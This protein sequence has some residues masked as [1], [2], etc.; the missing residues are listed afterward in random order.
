MFHP[1]PTCHDRR[2]TE[3]GRLA[4]HLK[5]QHHRRR[6]RAARV[7]DLPGHAAFCASTA[8]SS[9][10]GRLRRSSVYGRRGQNTSMTSAW[11]MEGQSWQKLH[12]PNIDASHATLATSLLPAAPPTSDEPRRALG[13]AASQTLRDCGRL[14]RDASG[15]SGTAGPSSAAEGGNLEIVCRGQPLSATRG[16]TRA[17]FR[18]GSSNYNPRKLF[19]T[20]MGTELPEALEGSLKRLCVRV[21]TRYPALPH[22]LFSHPVCLL[23]KSSHTCATHVPNQQLHYSQSLYI[24]Y[25]QSAN[26]APR[27]IFA[28]THPRAC[29][30]AFE[31]VRLPCN[32]MDK[33]IETLACRSS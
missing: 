24:I 2:A 31:R 18:A 4:G 27:P 33:L 1:W 32:C 22:L 6:I 11:A 10:R 28:A 13:G 23:D 30:T 3:A 8:L 9:L 20:Q 12:A 14:R 5:V 29:S 17:S 7:P 16:H 19:D 25:Q 15:N 21:S 26:M